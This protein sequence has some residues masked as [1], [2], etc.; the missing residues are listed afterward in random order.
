[1][2]FSGA[3][4][5]LFIGGRTFPA[6]IFEQCLGSFRITGG[7]CLLP[8]LVTAQPQVLPFQCLTF[9]RGKGQGGENY[10]G[11]HIAAKG[12][13]Q[14]WQQG[15]NEPKTAVVPGVKGALQLLALLAVSTVEKLI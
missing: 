15:Q 9:I 1:M 14:K 7:Q 4:V 13:Q 12:Q 10:K 2:F 3:K 11:Q 6:G 5:T 8:L